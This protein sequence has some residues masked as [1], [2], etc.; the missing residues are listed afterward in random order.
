MYLLAYW[1]IFNSLNNL[2]SAKKW[3]EF[4]TTGFT[5][6]TDNLSS[7]FMSFFVYIIYSEKFDRHY[8]GQTNNIEER[9]EHHNSGY[10]KSTAPYIPWVLKL[11][12]EKNTR[13]EA[14]ILERKL[15][16]LNREKLLQ[17]ISKYS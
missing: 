16:N 2:K 9:L 13:S 12:I 5:K 4:C 1:L 7:F 3:F 15:K 17:F 6:A 11:V 10:T 14:M 8:V